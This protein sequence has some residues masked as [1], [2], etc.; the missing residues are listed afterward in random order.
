MQLDQTGPLSCSSRQCSVIIRLAAS[1]RAVA[2]LL[3]PYEP[4][5]AL[6]QTLQTPYEHQSLVS[7][8]KHV[9]SSYLLQSGYRLAPQRAPPPPGMGEHHTPPATLLLIWSSSPSSLHPKHGPLSAREH[10]RL[11]GQRQLYHKPRTFSRGNQ[12][13][14]GILDAMPALIEILL[15]D[16]DAAGP[17]RSAQLQPPVQ[18]DHPARRQQSCSAMPAVIEIE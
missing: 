15:G 13:S 16:D 17:D 18:R 1:S 5:N 9:P 2:Y 12:N 3:E 14:R 8:T 6:G 11:A 7:R 10:P 4:S